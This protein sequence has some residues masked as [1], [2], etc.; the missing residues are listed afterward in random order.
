METWKNRVK[1]LNSLDLRFPWFFHD[2][3]DVFPHG[4]G[5]PLDGGYCRLA[6]RDRLLQADPRF[7][8][9]GRPPRG[10]APPRLL[11]A[12]GDPRPGVR[13]PRHGSRRRPPIDGIDCGTG[14][15][16]QPGGSRFLADL[17]P[18]PRPRPAVVGLEPA[19]IA[20]VADG[21]VELEAAGGEDVP[22]LARQEPQVGPQVGIPAAG[23]ARGGR[24]LVRVA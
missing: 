11:A 7:S 17:S 1:L 19:A 14:H 16:D 4:T 15:R 22:E 21:G 10:H 13:R 23:P 9:W 20:P 12:R 6:V 3:H 5:N 8:A 24:A 18:E 2:F